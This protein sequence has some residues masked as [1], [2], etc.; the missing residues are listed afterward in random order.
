M[1][2]LLFLAHRIPYPPNKGDKIRSWNLLRHLA[3]SY[4]VHLGCFVDDDA[5]WRYTDKVRELCA[6]CHFAPLHPRRA[7]LRSL[8]GLVRG[9]PLTLGYYRDRGFAAWVDER[10]AEGVDVAFIYSSSMA[11]YLL[12][13]QARPRLVVDFVDVDS[14]KWAQ[15]A[16][17]KPWPQS[18]IYGRESRTLLAFERHAAAH[19]AASLLVSPA[20]A[21][22]FRDLAPESADRVHAVNNGVDLEFFAPDGDHPDPFGGDG[23]DLVFTGAMD[24]WPNVDA[25]GWF[26]REVLPLLRR[27]DPRFHFTIV[28]GNPSPRVTELAREPGVTVTG[29]VADVRPYLAHAALVVAPLRVAR[30][31]QNKVLEAM[32]MARPVVAT[33]QALEGIDAAPGEELVVADGAAEFAAAVARLAGDP[34]RDAMGRRARARVTEHYGWEASL[35]PLDA[36]LDGDKKNPSEAPKKAVPSNA[37]ASIFGA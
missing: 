36:L 7:R 6:Q 30:G 4:R 21:Q 23:L 28:G 14:D 33:P 22:L 17:R 12:S 10:L 32:A 29:R 11:Q 37:M 16:K 2:D 1:R 18:W 26:A 8:A 5:D 15:Y 24:Y 27:E 20:E 35:R 34:E 25:V 19:A 3:R 31:I 13:A 9:Q